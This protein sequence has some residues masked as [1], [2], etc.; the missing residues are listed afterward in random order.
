MQKK[1][2]RLKTTPNVEMVGLD[3]RLPGASSQNAAATNTP[4]G[5]PIVVAD[6]PPSV[7]P[8]APGVGNLYMM[9]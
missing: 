5:P 8:E 9:S 6:G 3:V 1:K 2:G 7:D 4:G